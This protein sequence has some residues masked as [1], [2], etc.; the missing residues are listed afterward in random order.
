M[1]TRTA[2]W[3]VM[4]VVAASA[5]PAWAATDAEKCR[6]DKNQAAGKYAACRHKAE[7]KFV[8]TWTRPGTPMP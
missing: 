5:G 1:K 7:K 3:I 6:A 8:L 4:G 2:V